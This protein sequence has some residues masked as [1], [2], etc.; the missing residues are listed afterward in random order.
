MYFMDIN[1]KITT[2]RYGKRCNAI[3]GMDFFLWLIPTSNTV[4][5]ML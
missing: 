3:Y 1:S 2:D 4:F 5:I